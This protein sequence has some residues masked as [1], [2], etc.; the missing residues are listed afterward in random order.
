MTYL[1]SAAAAAVAAAAWRTW[2]SSEAHRKEGINGNQYIHKGNR[3][4]T[5]NKEQTNEGTEQRN[6]AQPTNRR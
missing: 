4:S 3:N 2:L 6:N 1:T 5:R